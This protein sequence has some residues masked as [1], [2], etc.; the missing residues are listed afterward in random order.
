MGVATVAEADRATAG[1]ELVL[2][3]LAVVTAAGALLGLLVGGVGGRLAM[4]VLARLNPEVTG[5]LSDDGFA[6]GT[7]SLATLNLLAV[8]TG[9]GVLGSGFYF[10]LRGLMIGPRWFQVLSIGVG[11]AVVVG[12]M[13]VHTD[14]VDFT[15]DPAWLAVVLFV[16]I[17]GGYA[18]LLTVVAERWLAD[19]GGWWRTGRVPALV[20]LLLWLPIAPALAA[21]L[22]VTAALALARRVGPLASLLAA[23]ATAWVARAALAVIFALALV[24]LAGDMRY[25]A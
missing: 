2:R 21:V 15:L 11:P 24:E 10:L 9:L 25:L 23:P 6:I 13:I 19:D 1:V 3:R 14:G 20:P 4:L 16:A 8:G 12:S 17:P 5:M 7:F 22:A 18:A